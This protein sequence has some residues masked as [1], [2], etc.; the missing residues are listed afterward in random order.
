M[1]DIVSS[2]VCDYNVITS[3]PGECAMKTR[4]IPIGNSRGVR[5]PKPLLEQAELEDDIE[6]RVVEGG[7]LVRGISPRRDGWSEA[8]QQVRERRE[9]GLL[10]DGVP[11]TFDESEWTW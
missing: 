5:I 3:Y 11:T 1:I 10:D 7:I 2:T 6:L 9:D 8:A 4:L